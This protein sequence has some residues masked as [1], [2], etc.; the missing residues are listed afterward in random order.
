LV[1]ISLIKRF[2]DI[3]KICS[4]CHLDSPLSR[5]QISYCHLPWKKLGF[6]YFLHEHIYVCSEIECICF[7]FKTNQK[8]TLETIL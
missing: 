7:L 4:N 1:N 6:I 5:F 8:V 2:Y 3:I